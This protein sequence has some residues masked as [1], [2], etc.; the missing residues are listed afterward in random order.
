MDK[1]RDLVIL[2]IKAVELPYLTLGKSANVEVGAK[3]YTISNPKG[4]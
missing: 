2:K 1:R 3:V 4:S